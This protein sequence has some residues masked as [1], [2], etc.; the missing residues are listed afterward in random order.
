[1]LPSSVTALIVILVVVLVLVAFLRMAFVVPSILV[2]WIVGVGIVVTAVVGQ[3]LPR[4]KLGQ[5]RT[6][7][8]SIHLHHAVAEGILDVGRSRLVRV[9]LDSTNR[10]VVV[11]GHSHH[12][13]APVDGP[14]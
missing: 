4:R 7:R 3:Y 14:T 11:A 2:V 9:R 6:P 5:A 10:F 1:M 13:S 12:H 8:R